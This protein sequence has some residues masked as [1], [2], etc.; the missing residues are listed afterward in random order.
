MCTLGLFHSERNEA[1]TVYKHPK[2]I[3]GRQGM[4]IKAPLFTTPEG[5]N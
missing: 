5:R 2:A 1:S 3:I 4:R